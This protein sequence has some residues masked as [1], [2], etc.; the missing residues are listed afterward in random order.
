VLAAGLITSCGGAPRVAAEK[1]A[2]AEPASTTPHDRYA[3][4][5]GRF[6][7]GMPGIPGSPFQER[8]AEPAWKQHAAIFDKSWHDIEAGRL[9]AMREFQKSDLSTQSIENSVM[10]YPFS[11]PDVLSASIFF[12]NNKTY[13]MVAW[14]PAGTLPSVKQ[15]AKKSLESHLAA[16]RETLGDII[17]RS[18]FV[19]RQ[20][21]KQLRGQVE[22][23][24]LPTLL[25]LL[26]RTGHTVLGFRPVRIDEDSRVIDRPASYTSPKEAG[27]FGNMGVE[28]EFQTDADKSV[29]KLYY[30]KADLADGKLTQNK[31]L[32]T[33]IAG[34]KGLATFFKSTSYMVHRPEFSAI[35]NE[36][37]DKSVSVLQD[38][39]GIPY[40]FFDAAKW[41]VQLYGEYDKPYRPFQ[42]MQQLD[43]KAAFGEPG[44]KPLG[45]RIGYGYA[46][47]PSNL[48]LA[49]HK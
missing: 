3:N 25:I 8:E 44:I 41:Q 42:Y 12:P 2:A 21:D 27:K 11:G 49:K 15:L 30:F 35:R 18:F 22:D 4:D 37:L 36:V 17:S 9:K 14:E 45:F 5:V 38:D 46:K 24:V 39:S 43:L 40:K 34:L 19:T 16:T 6:L 13:V 31:P 28:I 20:M 7:A 33:Y 26:A 1:P 23:G 29:H 10:F 47:I 48:L 32:L